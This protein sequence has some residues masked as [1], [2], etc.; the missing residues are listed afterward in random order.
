MNKINTMR[1]KLLFEQ[2]YQGEETSNVEM[3]FVGM[4]DKVLTI[5]SYFETECCTK[6]VKKFPL[7]HL[8]NEVLND[9]LSN[10][11]HAIESNFV[12]ISNCSRCEKNPK[13]KRDYANHVFIEV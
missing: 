9:D 11:E 2:F 10:M 4:V 6:S 1:A 7:I 5:P 3:T 12:E 8:N 13:F